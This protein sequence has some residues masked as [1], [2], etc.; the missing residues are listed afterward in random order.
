MFSGEYLLRPLA[1]RVISK[2]LKLDICGLGIISPHVFNFRGLRTFGRNE[3]RFC[4]TSMGKAF[5]L[6]MAPLGAFV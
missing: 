2:R 3:F 5:A 4:F 6:Y 1:P